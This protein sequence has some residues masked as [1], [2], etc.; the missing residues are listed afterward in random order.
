[1]EIK[2]IIELPPITKK[3][4]QQILTNRKTGRP[5]IGPSKQYKAYEKSALWFLRKRPEKPLEGPLNIKALFYMPTRRKT[6]LTNLLEAIDDILVEAEIIADDNYGVIAAHDGSRCYYDKE[7]PR[8]EI[9]I[10]D[11]V[12]GVS[13]GEKEKDESEKKTGNSGRCEK[14]NGES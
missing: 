8:T 4:S 3:N 7:N 11:F 14:G 1:M 2:Y 12:E 6:D 13:D 5:F 10:T 9:Y